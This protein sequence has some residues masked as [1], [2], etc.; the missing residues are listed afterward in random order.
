MNKLTDFIQ[1]NKKR[2]II[3]AVLAVIALILCCTFYQWQKGVIFA[4]MFL[5]LGSIDLKPKK[6]VTICLFY[7]LWTI[8]VFMATQ[9]ASVT[10]I[11][12][13]PNFWLGTIRMTMNMLC[14][15]IVY[16]AVLIISGRHKM[17]VVISS[18]LLMALLIINGIVY[19]F[20]GKELGIA[21]VWSMTTALSV[22]GQY[23]VEITRG[24]VYGWLVWL[25]AIFAGE[26]L[27]EIK[28]TK[29]TL[30]KCRVYGVVA[31]LIS[32]LAL[33]NG[34]AGMSIHTWDKDGTLKNG[35]FL[36]FFL[37]IR[38]FGADKPAEYRAAAVDSFANEYTAEVAEPQKKPNIIV[39]MDEAFADVRV[40]GGELK[41]DKPATPFIDSL[42]EN[43]VKG[44]AL[45]SVYGGNTANSEFEFLTGHSLAF[46][47]QGS[48]PYQQYIRDEM[49]A[50]PQVMKNYG[51]TTMATHP[52][53][54]KGWSRDKI[55]PLFGFDESEFI[56][57]YPKEYLLR[58]YVS[59]RVMFERVVEKIK[60][61]ENE[62][63]VFLF[64]ITMQNHGGYNDPYYEDTVHLEGYSRDYSQSQQYLSL[65]KDTD[66]AVR[67][68]LTE[69]ENFGEDTL[70][71]FFGDHLP[72]VELEFFEELYGGKFEK[73]EGK[74][75]Q[76]KIPFFIW[77]NYD[78][79]EKTVEC[80]SLNYLAGHLL[81]TAGL[82]L[83]P[84]HRF[85]KDAE[86]VIPAMNVLGYRRAGGDFAE[87]SEATEDEK[88]WLKKYAMAQYN[89]IFDV[90]NRNE[91]FFGKER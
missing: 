44:Y 37:G 85:L 66:D 15:F 45:S 68:L 70:V 73:I 64:G 3:G 72:S 74:M 19:Q 47:P 49:Y 86:K 80:T 11:N 82:P 36:N 63:P 17:S 40:F 5:V 9:L 27:P 56:D 7:V 84:Y 28:Y 52:Y 83:P 25:G 54:E 31:L 1:F 55:Y 87:Y 35:Y 22:M 75:L 89:N 2:G 42:K 12:G 33:W 43:T 48:V 58:G 67:Y 46:L 34:S 39:I 41:T 61:A 29:I 88:Q 32:L 14:I 65:I 18:T 81:E 77:A 62:N 38:D 59:D 8:S 71:L 78:I 23:K 13:L 51:Y 30:T 79:Q 60:S 53:G 6:P 4:A 57:A 50:L 16:I 69:L 91:T 10:T 21:D 76:H 24:M 90:K 20:R 26:T